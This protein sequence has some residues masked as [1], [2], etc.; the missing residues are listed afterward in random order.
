MF[1]RFLGLM[2]IVRALS[3]VLV[4]VIVAVL[5]SIIIQDL[6]AVLDE[7][8]RRIDAEFREIQSVVERA[9]REV[10]TLTRTITTVVNNLR[11]FR[12]PNLIPDLPASLTIPQINLGSVAIPI[13]EIS[14]IWSNSP[15][16][17]Y[18]SS[19][20]FSWSSGL[21]VN[22]S[23]FSIR[24]PSSISVR[25]TS[26]GFN[27]PNIPQMSLPLP[28]LREVSDL[29]RGAF[30]SITNVF[31]GFDEAF[32]SI[33]SLG[34]SLHTLTESFNTVVSE[35]KTALTSMRDTV[36]RWGSL[37]GA[38]GIALLLLAAVYFVVPCID[39]FRRGWRLLRGLPA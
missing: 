3:P 13:P 17:R 19:L 10:G 1:Q 8:V 32:A 18:P 25:T 15:T 16:I 4:I 29:L 28:G 7:P 34:G 39:D 30:G 36:L 33:S 22:W 2:L 37:L 5:G 14:V 24:Y 31:D 27:L 35:S 6:L 11:S 21:S 23:D 12:L 20:G 26:Y 9:R 38:A